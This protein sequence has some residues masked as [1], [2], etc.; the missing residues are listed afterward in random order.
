M[1]F[2]TALVDFLFIAAYFFLADYI[3]PKLVATGRTWLWW[4]ILLALVGSSYLFTRWASPVRRSS[5]SRNSTLVVVAYSLLLITVFLYDFSTKPFLDKYGI[6]SAW[7][8]SL[9]LT[10]VAV[11]VGMWKSRRGD[12][13]SSVRSS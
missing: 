8:V 9:L 4:L 5:A 12:R 1:R 10:F 7:S 11:A 3:G 13:G 2:L 6:G